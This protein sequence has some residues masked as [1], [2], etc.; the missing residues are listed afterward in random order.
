MYEVYSTNLKDNCLGV[1]KQALVNSWDKERFDK[2][3]GAQNDIALGSY[4]NAG[5]LLVNLKE[6]RDMNIDDKLISLS[7]KGFNNNDQDLLNLVYQGKVIFLPP[8]YNITPLF[9]FFDAL[10]EDFLIEQFSEKWIKDYKN[11]PAIIHYCTIKPWNIE[12]VEIVN[13]EPDALKL[14]FDYLLLS[15]KYIPKALTWDIFSEKIFSLLNDKSSL[16]NDRSWLS[17]ELEPFKN[18]RWARFGILSMNGKIKFIIKFSIKFILRKVGIFY[19][20]KKMIDKNKKNKKL[21]KYIKDNKDFYP[22]SLLNEKELLN[23]NTTI[24]HILGGLGNQIAHY[25]FAKQ[26][27]EKHPGTKVVLFNLYNDPNTET[28]RKFELDKLFDLKDFLVISHLTEK[29]EYSFEKLLEFE[30]YLIEYKNTIIKGKFKGTYFFKE[31]LDNTKGYYLKSLFF[32]KKYHKDL[33]EKIKID[34]LI[35]E[36]EL[37]VE[38]KKLLKN[39]KESNSVSIH[40]RRG[41]L[42]SKAHRFY[43][44]VGLFENNYYKDAINYI[45]NNIDKPKFFIFF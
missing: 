2:Y 15:L 41:D 12:K 33:K 34:N 10:S 37:T 38:N 11:N 8:R 23:E 9:D 7:S 40:V 21:K 22:A 39:I 27:Q 5:F 29:R 16:L 25:A 3:K 32:D 18:S 6:I 1:V 4:F 31:I 45:Y 19:A 20:I 43:F 28:E 24:I 30:N 35:I 36:K 44:D 14:W 17:N 13:L 42:M 26:I